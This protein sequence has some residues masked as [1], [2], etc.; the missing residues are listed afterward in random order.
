MTYLCEVGPNFEGNV[1]GVGTRTG[2]YDVAVVKRDKCWDN[3][4]RHMTHVVA[5]E[6]KRT[7]GRDVGIKR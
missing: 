7:I 6:E 3:N 2:M 5:I 1:R 4:E